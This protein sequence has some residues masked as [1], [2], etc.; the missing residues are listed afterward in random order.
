AMATLG[1]NIVVHHVLV[2]WDR[3]TGG[4]SGLTGIPSFGSLGVIT[5]LLS[6]SITIYWQYSLT[7]GYGGDFIAPRANSSSV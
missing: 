3:V 7:S 2:H 1:F 6:L 5:S 4:P